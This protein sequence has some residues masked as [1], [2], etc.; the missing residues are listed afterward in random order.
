[1]IE[2]SEVGLL[3]DLAEGFRDEYQT[4]EDLR[5]S[6]SPF[7]WIKLLPS[8]TKGN[9]GERLVKRWCDARGIKVAVA[10]GTKADLTLEG[11][12]TEIKMSTL[13][14]KGVYKFQQIRDQDYELLVCLGISPLEAHVWVLEKDFLIRKIGKV[15]G[16][17]GQHKGADAQDTAWLSVSPTAVHSWMNEFGGDLREAMGRLKTLLGLSAGK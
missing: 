17:T 16:L 8:A 14:K 2:D 3:A 5:W 1:M 15:P 9:V 13:W 10:P 12:R 6:R 4:E 11:R 7:G